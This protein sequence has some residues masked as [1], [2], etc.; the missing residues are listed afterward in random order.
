MGST[1]R[2]HTARPHLR[3]MIICNNTPFAFENEMI[4]SDLFLRT[5]P[6]PPCEKTRPLRL[7]L[8]SV[9]R[10]LNRT[11]MFFSLYLPP[12]I[13]FSNRINTLKRMVFLS[14]R[15]FCCY[16]NAEPS[17]IAICDNLSFKIEMRSLAGIRVSFNC[18]RLWSLSMSHRLTSNS[19]RNSDYKHVIFVIPV[20]EIETN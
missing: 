10:M 5:N 12:S 9:S 3:Q 8:R 19:F 7:R 1:I 13:L 17:D 4:C 20:L 15:I 18:L 16:W 11:K 2:M 6:L 14:K